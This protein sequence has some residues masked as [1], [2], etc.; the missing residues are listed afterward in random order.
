M[1]KIL[2]LI[3]L[4][5]SFSCIA[6]TKS[7]TQI[8]S[9]KDAK[10]KPAFDIANTTIFKDGTHLVFRQKLYGTAGS[11][12]PESIGQ[13]AN[14]KVAGYVWP[15]NLDTSTV[16]FAPKQG[17]LALAVT[18]HPDFDDTPLFDENN[19]GDKNND[20]NEWHSHW[21]VLVNDDQ[22]G[23]GALK[24]KD[25]PANSK[26]KLPNTVPG[27]PILLDSPGFKPK[28]Y[29]KYIEVRIPLL[30]SKQFSY[31]GVTAYLTVNKQG[32]APLLC[33]T[34]VNDIASGDLSLPGSL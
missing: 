33:V 28:T 26:P 6:A 7:T 32:K 13:L 25:I 4:T 1:K 34:K 24:V 20:G 8:N 23:K 5:V 27:L 15:T 31:D 18:A 17:I 11:I 3:C 19:D 22:C 14:S 30:K 10:I 12:K 9:K 2:F 29:D 21:V 16:G